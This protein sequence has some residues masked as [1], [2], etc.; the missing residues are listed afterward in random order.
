[1]IRCCIFDLDGTLLNTLDTIHYYV[2]LA[3]EKAGYPGVSKDDTRRFVGNGAWLLIERAMRS[4]GEKNE[5]CIARVHTIYNQLYD[6]DPL[7]LTAPYS[8]I[9]EILKTLKDREIKVAVLS[10]KPHSATEPIVRSFF[11]EMVDI[12]RGGMEGVPL[13]PDPT[14]GIMI[15][16]SFGVACEECAF[17]GD[18]AVDVRMGKAIGARLSIGV[19][20][21]FRDREE[22]LD[23]DAIVDTA[24]NLIATITE[25]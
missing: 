4:V 17:I 24:E 10:N 25:A 21:G 12:A 9:P 20:W 16:D 15:L 2:N 18:T 14:A 22:L 8:G 3:M 6:A 1:M 19:S 23:A 5:A 7:Y 11:G 13:K